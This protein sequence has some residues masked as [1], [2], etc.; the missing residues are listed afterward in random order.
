MA[1]FVGLTGGIGSGKST[2]SDLLERRGAVVVDADK[3]VHEIQRPGEEAFDEIVAEFGE[4]VVAGDGTLDRK[5]LA[6]IVFNDEAKLERL[7]A[8]THPRVGA[9][10]AECVSELRPTDRVVV[11]DIP[12]LGASKEGSG[13]V[14]DRIVVVTAP[15]SI[16]LDRLEERGMA[17]GD[18]EARMRAQM[19]D[20]ER[21]ALADDVIDNSGTLEDLERQVD[22][23]WSRLEEVAAGV[24]G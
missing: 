19:S 16:R 9:R 11:L 10:F 13:R 4:A 22:E 12:L 24:D 17:R 21:V 8:I 23:L 5:A 6:D 2:V 1:Y 15:E 18:A 20:E 14:A 7:N 3:I